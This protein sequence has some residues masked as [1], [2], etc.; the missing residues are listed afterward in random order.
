MSKFV[1]VWIVAIIVCTSGLLIA[2]TSETWISNL[3]VSTTSTTATLTWTT[4]VPSSTQV[5]YGLT[6]SYGTHTTVNPTL[7]TAHAATIAGL[8]PSTLYHFRLVDQDA[9]P[10]A[11]GSID[12]TMTTQANPVAVV[13]TPAAASIP[14]GGS[15]QLTAQVTNASNTAVTWI[16]SAGTV[17]AAGLFTAPSVTANFQVIVTATSVADNSK[18]AQA[19]ITVTAPIQHS[20][21]LQWQASPSSEIQFYSAYRSLM[22]GGPYSLLAS[23]ITGLGYTDSSVQSG[24]TYYYVVTATNSSGEESADSAEV[25]AGVPN[26]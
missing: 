13:V 4:A 15:Q 9:E 10:L 17:T 6:T 22:K 26:P 11:L 12:Y 1:A 18:S 16:S 23:A 19:V 14:S 25:S 2:Q 8:T 24:T 7:V 5:R 20:V 21:L 3:N